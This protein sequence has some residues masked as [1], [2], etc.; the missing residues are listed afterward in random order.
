LIEQDTFFGQS[1]HMGCRHPAQ[2]APNAI[3]AHITIAQVI[4]HQEY[5]IWSV[6]HDFSPF[7]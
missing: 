5:N 4:G 1:I 2:L 7:A 3:A 6:A